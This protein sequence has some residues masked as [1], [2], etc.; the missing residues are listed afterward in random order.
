MKITNFVVPAAALVTTACG[1]RG[2][3]PY[4]VQVE[5]E[6]RAPYSTTTGDYK[7]CSQTLISSRDKQLQEVE[8]AIQQLENSRMIPSGTDAYA[9]EAR[10]DRWLRKYGSAS[11]REVSFQ[12][13]V[14]LPVEHCPQRHVRM[15]FG[16]FN[17]TTLRNRLGQLRNYLNSY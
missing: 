6:S 5:G 7:E 13:A 8:R 1:P 12:C 2:S 10:T 15:T 11:C 9:V 14:A 16:K 17:V 3:S 4:T